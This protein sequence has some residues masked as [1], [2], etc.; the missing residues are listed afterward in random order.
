[1]KHYNYGLRAEDRLAGAYARRGH[2]TSYYERSRGPADLFVTR[3]AR[4]LYIQVRSTRSKTVRIADASAAFVV[5][6][7][8]LREKDLERLVAHATRNRGQPAVGLTHGDYYWTWR[9]RVGRNEYGF[10][11][12][13]HGWL[14]KR[15]LGR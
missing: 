14:P 3:G 6:S 8:R 9:V 12:L 4:R 2:A 10:D 11:L 1:M 15:P 7:G 5:L 13:H